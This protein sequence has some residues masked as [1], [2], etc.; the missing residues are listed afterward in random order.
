MPKL[1]TLQQEIKKYFTG[2]KVNPKILSPQ[3]EKELSIYKS[4]AIENL[5]KSMQEAFPLCYKILKSYWEEIILDFY[6][7]AP[8]MS[9]IY[10]QLTRNFPVYLKSLKFNF[11]FKKANFPKWLHE[12]AEYEWAELDLYNFHPQI[13]SSER[14]DSFSEGDYLK[15][16]KAHRIFKFTYPISKIV[17][18]LNSKRKAYNLNFFKKQKEAL[19]IFR[20]R[21]DKVRSFLLSSG[22]YFL[23]DNLRYG[24]ELGNLY[25]KFMNRFAISEKDRLD[26][27]RKIQD[28]LSNFKEYGILT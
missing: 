22:T 19:L 25:K 24:I 12:L 3:A 23:V 26:T 16:P 21:K 7:N 28:L 2:K 4:L 17:D 6:H 18:H 27:N 13:I 1:Y 5:S 8:S 9:G 14:K 10:L 20:D 11:K 15:L